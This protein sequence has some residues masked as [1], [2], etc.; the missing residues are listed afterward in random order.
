LEYAA[1]GAFR[2]IESEAVKGIYSGLRIILPH[3]IADYILNHKR[4][5][6]LKLESTFSLSLHIAGSTETAW[7]KLEIQQIIKENTFDA[8][9]PQEET[10]LKAEET[11]EFVTDEK[12]TVN[13]EGTPKKKSRRRPRY[14]KRKPPE[15]VTETSPTTDLA[16]ATDLITPAPSG[17]NLPVIQNQQTESVAFM[18]EPAKQKEVTITSETNESEIDMMET[19]KKDEA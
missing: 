9:E 11:S 10:L 3:E 17:E 16:P 6:L 15:I 8:P 5:E 14:K 19:E 12:A 7:D 18:I 13:G 1:L 2:K 4:S